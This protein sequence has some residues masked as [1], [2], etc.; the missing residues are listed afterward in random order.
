MEIAMKAVLFAAVAALGLLA[1]QVNAEGLNAVEAPA[2][3]RPMMAGQT[4]A[5]VGSEAMP[6]FGGGHAFAQTRLVLRDTGSEATPQWDLLGKTT[7]LGLR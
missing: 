4:G 6:I 3:V 1:G 2:A 7:V 5:D